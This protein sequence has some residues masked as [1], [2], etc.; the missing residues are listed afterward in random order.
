[1]TGYVNAFGVYQDYY[2]LNQLGNKS[3]SDISWIGSVQLAMVSLV[4]PLSSNQILMTV[5]CRSW[6]VRYCRGKLSM[7]AISRLCWSEGRLSTLL[8][9]LM[10]SIYFGYVLMDYFL[11][12][13]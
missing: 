12:V 7:P 8:G 6:R 10:S 2:S 9:A 1:M 13:A 11:L 3:A 4:L 5:M